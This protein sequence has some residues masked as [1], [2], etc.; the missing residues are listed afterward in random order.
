MHLNSLFDLYYNTFDTD[1][2]AVENQ[3]AVDSAAIISKHSLFEM[4][5]NL[6]RN[7]SEITNNFLSKWGNFGCSG[8]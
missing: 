6:L 2:V 4:V 1:F 5:S 7:I 3:A 8:R